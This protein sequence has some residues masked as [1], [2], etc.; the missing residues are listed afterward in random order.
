MQIH[1]LHPEDVKAEI[2]KRFGTVR[3]FERTNGLPIGGVRDILR[4]RTSERIERAI[5]SVLMEVSDTP[6][7]RSGQPKKSVNHEKAAG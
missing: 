6:L 7:Q 1:D 5:E 2:R 3:D 4:G